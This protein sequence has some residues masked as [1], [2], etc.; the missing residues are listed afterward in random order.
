MKNNECVEN[1][2]LLICD[3]DGTLVNKNSEA[4]FLRFLTQKK[5][6]RWYHYLL[7]ALSVP[8]NR[9]SRCL[10]G[11]DLLRAWSAFRTER[12]TQELF[13]RF[14][15]ENDEIKL[16]ESVLHQVEQH[17]GRKMLLTGSNQRL[18]E[19]LLG[20]LGLQ[21]VFDVIIG[22]RTAKCGYIVACHP[23]GRSKNRYLDG[24]CLVGIGNEY[25]DRFFLSRCTT[26]YVVHPDKK[27]ER[28]AREKGWI[29]L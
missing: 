28:L 8:V 7:A 6:L 23:Y 25:A 14:L 10:G 26:A 18:V 19:G 29:I 9:I 17:A 22:A 21:G 16:N 2:P 27:L 1:T 3:F 20:K 13:L 15:T 12:E 4:T 11:N 24:S 5:Q